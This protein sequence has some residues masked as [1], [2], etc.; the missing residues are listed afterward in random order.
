[1]EENSQFENQVR[2]IISDVTMYSFINAYKK[3]EFVFSK[4][5]TTFVVVIKIKIVI[6]W[7]NK[8]KSEKKNNNE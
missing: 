1:M 6:I 2:F 5:F 3:S 4:S 8:N 7:K